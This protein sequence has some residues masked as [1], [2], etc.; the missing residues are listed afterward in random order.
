MRSRGSLIS[1]LMTHLSPLTAAVLLSLPGAAWAAGPYLTDLEAVG[2][3]QAGAFVAS[4]N[5]L[6]A[7]WY[8]P[9]ALAGQGGLRMQLEGGLHLTNNRYQRAPNPDTGQE[10]LLVTNLSPLKPA[11]FGAVT[12]DFGVQDLAVGVAVYSPTSGN[13][14]FPAN[15]PQRYQAVGADSI[16]LHMHVGVAYRIF[17]WLS[18]GVTF[19][20]TYLQTEQKIALTA[21]PGD[22]EDRNFSV[23]FTTNVTDPFTI[24]SNFGVRVEPIKQLAIG[25]SIMP[26][27][28]INATGTASVEIP[29]ALASQVTLNGNKFGLNASFPMILRAGV[30]YRP[31]ERLSVEGAFVWEQWSRN[32]AVDLIPDGIT[33]NFP[34]VAD[35]LAIPTIVLPKQNRDAFSARL[36][37]EGRPHD[38]VTLR[39]GIFYESGATKPQLYDLTAPDGHKVGIAAGVSIHLWK[40]SIDAA[41]VHVFAP[42]LTV[43][44]TET[45][46]IQVLPTGTPG[47]VGNGNYN[48]STDMFHLGI[49]ATFFDGPRTPASEP[50][51]VSSAS[52]PASD[53]ASAPSSTPSL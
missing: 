11:F 34:G 15:G 22:P 29:E 53:V 13:Y 26:P 37:I 35:N 20:N 3:G 10:Y 49:R 38:I 8:N 21:S 2:M 41:Y 17:S 47:L 44:D 42:Q 25:L 30:R 48:F 5:T 52:A 4:P 28:D 6:S 39:G 1:S 45:T 40:F 43:T 46:T 14:Q 51:Q 24:T 31:L 19:G 50:V 7:F 9:A 32:K 12:Y 18:L 27:Y 33:V 36:G 16:A 23:P